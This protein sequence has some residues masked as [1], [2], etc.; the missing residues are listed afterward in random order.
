[1]AVAAL[2]LWNVSAVRADEHE[3]TTTT[4]AEPTTT[5]E[6]EPTTTTEVPGQLPLLDD[7]AGPTRGEWLALLLVVGV[8]SGAAVGRAVFAR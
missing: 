2:N 4:E 8:G 1:M 5:T 3:P 6:A 7:P